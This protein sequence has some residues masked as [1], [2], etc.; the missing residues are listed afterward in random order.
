MRL[1]YVAMT[2]AES[3][4]I[5]C[6]TEGANDGAE[7]WHKLVADGV[8]KAGAV[9][10][11]A[12][13][14]IGRRHEH[15]SWPAPMAIAAPEA[16]IEFVLPDWARERPPAAVAAESAL[17]PSALGGA[18]ALP[19]EGALDEETALR[20]WTMLHRLLEHL[21]LWPEPDWPDIAAGLLSGGCLE[22]D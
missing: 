18:K 22:G 17:S 11:P 20:R 15:G 5:V 10:L 13:G 4:L 2:R 6:G 14:G 7:S 1:L 19:G 9:D 21:P 3:W 12:E 16:P 8:E